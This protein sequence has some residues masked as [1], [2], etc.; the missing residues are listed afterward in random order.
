MTIT[1]LSRMN[2]VY[3]IERARKN[4]QAKNTAKYALTS[5]AVGVGGGLA[6]NSMLKHEN[7]AA[8]VYDAIKNG[9]K[10][11]F[12][13]WNPKGE[14][15][16]TCK[17]VTK[18]LFSK[19][20]SKIKSPKAKALAMGVAFVAYPLLVIGNKLTEKYNY[21]KGRIDQKYH[22]RKILNCDV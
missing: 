14:F 8:K 9:T 13:K 4:E 21:N 5:G 16:K 11:L 7:Q 2:A 6:L 15:F 3:D 1:A 17:E 20:S 19:V 12:N 22:D 18:E 10:K